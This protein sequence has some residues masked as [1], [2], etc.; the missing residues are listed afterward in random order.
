LLQRFADDEIALGGNLILRHHIIRPFVIAGIDLASL[1]E[2]DEIDGLLAL[3]PKSP[4]APSR[5]LSERAWPNS[6][7]GGE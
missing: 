2:L 1:N 6:N 4:P 7:F 3:Q 5:H